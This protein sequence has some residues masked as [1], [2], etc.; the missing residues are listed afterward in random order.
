MYEYVVHVLF[1]CSDPVH[2]GNAENIP[3]GIV[4]GFSVHTG[5]GRSN[6]MRFYGAA[7]ENHGKADLSA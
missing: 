1:L 3:A 5:F 7:T 2:K 6:S 4:Y